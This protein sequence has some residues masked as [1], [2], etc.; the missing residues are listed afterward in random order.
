MDQFEHS[1]LC[2]YKLRYEYDSA[3]FTIEL[4]NDTAHLLSLAMAQ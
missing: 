3:V 1:N 4:V 2:L